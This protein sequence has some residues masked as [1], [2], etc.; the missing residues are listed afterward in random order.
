MY[1]IYVLYIC[2]SCLYMLVQA[3]CPFRVMDEYDVFLDEASRQNTLQ[4]CIYYYIAIKY[5]CVCI[6]YNHI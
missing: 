6:L 5:T 1:K 2:V 3:E 4:V